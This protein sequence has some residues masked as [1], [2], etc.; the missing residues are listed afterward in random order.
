VVVIAAVTIFNTFK[1]KIYYCYGHYYR[2]VKMECT[3]GPILNFAP[4]VKLCPQGR[5]CP[6]RVNFVPWGCFYP[7]GM[8]FSVCLSILLNSRECS[9]LGVNEGVSIPPK[10]QSSPLGAGGKVKN[11]P[12]RFTGRFNSNFGETSRATWQSVF[13]FFFFYGSPTG[14]ACGNLSLRVIAP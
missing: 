7:L 3:L 4:R 5:S 12:R 6:P 13:F 1:W 14:E 11:G 9:P 8:K 2:A 10:G